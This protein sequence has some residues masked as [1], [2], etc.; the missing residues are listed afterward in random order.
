VTIGIGVVCDHGNYVVL[1]SDKRAS[2]KNLQPNDETGKIFDFDPLRL[3][4]TVAG[5][6]GTLHEIVGELSVQFDKLA[7]KRSG[8]PIYREHVENA[9]DEAR[10]RQLARR[11]RWAAR[12]NYGLTWEQLLTGKLPHGEMNRVAWEDIKQTV[13]SVSLMAEIIVG[14]YVAD[15]PVLFKAAGKQEIEGSADPPV[16]VIG[17]TGAAY[18]MEHLNRRG[19]NI[20]SSFAQTVL[21]IHEA[22]EIAR[23]KDEGGHIGRCDAYVVL[24]RHRQGFEQFPHAC[25]LLRGWAK[26]YAKRDT[27]T[28]LKSGFAVNQAQLLLRPLAPGVRFERYRQNT[29]TAKPK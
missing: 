15:E 12:A 16:F 8:K 1:A 3:V 9:I 2:Y 28:S 6:L 24:H 20:F 23:K 27:T 7:K 5:R 26:A 10:F 4:G 25:H 19:Q 21:H 11:Y 13:F 14:G 22:M 29:K 18:A 17:S